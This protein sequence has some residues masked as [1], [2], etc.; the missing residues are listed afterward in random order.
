METDAGSPASEITPSPDASLL[1]SWAAGSRTTRAIVGATSEGAFSVDIAQDG[2][3]AFI[4]GTTG[5]GKTELLLTFITALALG[6]RP[7]ALNVIV[8]DWKGG[9]DFVELGGLPHTVGMVTNLDGHLAKRALAS[10]QAEVGRRQTVLKNLK[11]ADRISES[12]IRTLWDEQAD[13]ASEHGMA[14]LVIVVDEFA[15]LAQSIPEFLAG[16]VRIARV[17]RALGI[18]LVLATQ[19]PRGVITGDLSA[20]VG[21]RLVLR[22]ESGESREVLESDHA[23]HISRRTRGR[24]FVRYGDPPRLVE[25]Q[26]A[27]VAGRRPGAVVGLQDPLVDIVGWRDMGY[28]LR[29]PPQAEDQPDAESTDLRALVDMTRRVADTMSLKPPPSPWLPPLPG[30]VDLAEL[31]APTGRLSAPFGLIDEPAS[32][33]Q[34]T[35]LFDL[36]RDGHLAIAGSSGSGRSTALR[37]LAASL[38][39]HVAPTDCN[40]Y[41]F[42]FGNGGLLALSDLPHVGAIVR[43]SEADRV[44]RVLDRLSA[45]VTTR[46]ALM[47]RAQAGNIADQRALDPANAL[48]HIVVLIDR[49][50]SFVSQYPLDTQ[51]HQIILR[52]ARDGLGV[53]IHLVMSGDRYLLGGRMGGE[54]ERKLMLPFADRDDYRDGRL[55]PQDLPEVIAPGRGF[56]A[57]SGAEV[58]IAAIG[59]DDSGPALRQSI[60]EIARAA[61]ASADPRRATGELIRVEALPTAISFD[62]V[63]QRIDST[64][65]TSPLTALLA[66]GGDDLSPELIDFT[67]IGPG[68]TVAGPPGSGRSTALVS[69]ARS[70]L[71]FGAQVIA[72]LPRTSPVGSIPSDAL[73]IVSPVDLDA[74]DL[75]ARFATGPTVLIVDDVH[76]LS[77]EQSVLLRG[78]VDGF[79]AGGEFGFAV[80]GDIDKLSLLPV[81]MGARRSGSGLLL[82]PRNLDRDLLSLS[83]LPPTVVGRQPPGRGFLARR[84]NGHEVQVVN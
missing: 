83:A 43:A 39:K 63:W 13:L 78:L 60:G 35:I 69:I 76:L 26:T 22:T 52:L 44:A 71:A 14:R 73:H 9:G 6:N 82:S 25:F 32:Q 51:A 19:R 42:D 37:T 23:D 4:A 5:S 68:F 34:R 18:H 80:A 8:V 77:A 81:A 58:Q 70:V 45:E 27:R 53:G 57:D 29:R 2:P 41:G 7:E 40:I 31:A 30:H 74:D 66:V 24:G 54:F 48:A 28:A 3:H 75:A 15:E 79:A 49:W 55:R 59:D 65:V 36:E 64:R 16:L 12:N 33:S 20:N 11:E 50:D 38:A 46:Q 61:A 56:M 1:T 17:G 72:V 62:E 47:G 21:L 67:D 10:L 84:S